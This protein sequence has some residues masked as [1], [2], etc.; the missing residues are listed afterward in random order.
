MAEE[1]LEI[2]K[3]DAF[4]TESFGGNPAGVVLDAQGLQPEQMQ[5]IAS[6]MQASE[7]AFVLGLQDEV[8]RL[9]FFSPL[10]EVEFCGHASVAAISALVWSGR[11]QLQSEVDRVIIEA[12]TAR[13]PAAI[14]PHPVCGVE[15][16]LEFADLGIKPVAARRDLIAGVLGVGKD[17]VPERWPLA[18]SRAG[19]WS[20]VVPMA[21]KDVV[22]AAC[23]DQVLLTQ[24]NRKL[25][26][27]VTMIYTWQGP[28]DLYCRG[29]APAVGIPEDPVTGTGLAAV[30]ALMVS[31]R[32]LQLSPPLTRLSAEQGTQ[33]GRP[34]HAKFEVAHQDHKVLSVRIFGTAVKT[35]HGKIRVPV[36]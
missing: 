24:L 11:L 7:T 32:A 10:A 34:G 18:L 5:K 1:T 17:D 35:L 2:W 27:T 12:G 28:T 29:F 36:I 4:T 8:V 21:R 30:A 22:D 20:L 26:V 6:E 9:R 15:V 33:V 16:M 14:H 19:M 31:E 3:V 25:G 23:P 13:V